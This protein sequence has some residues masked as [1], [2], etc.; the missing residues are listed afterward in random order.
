MP[1]HQGLNMSKTK[2]DDMLLEMIQPKIN[3]IETKFS[4][5][6]GLNQED[7]NTLLLKSQYNHIN[8]LDSKL[9]EVT[10]SV[11]ALG[12]KFNL[13]EARFEALEA[14]VQSSLKEFDAKLDSLKIEFEGKFAEQKADMKALK[15][16]LRTEIKDTINSNMKWSIGLIAFIVVGLKLIDMLLA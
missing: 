3:E 2:V 11:I 13:L 8:H 16:E 10:S 1:P 14:R 4:S 12:G 15:Q 9:N 5:G 7:I 6:E